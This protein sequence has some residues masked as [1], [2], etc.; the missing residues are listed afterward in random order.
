MAPF[1]YVDDSTPDW[2]KTEVDEYGTVLYP[3]VSKW[4]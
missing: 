2:E 3:V 1:G 4:L